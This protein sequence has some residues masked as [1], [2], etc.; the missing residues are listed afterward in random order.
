LAGSGS[1]GVSRI[2]EAVAAN[3]EMDTMCFSFLGTDCG[4]NATVGNFAVA[5][6]CVFSLDRFAACFHAVAN[7]LSKAAEFLGKAMCPDVFLDALY[8]VSVFLDL[9]GDG[10]GD[11]VGKMDGLKMVGFG[12][13]DVVGGTTW[14]ALGTQGVAVASMICSVR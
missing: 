8:E 3:C 12:A 13:G 14:V 10:I 9:A 5:W 7:T 6:D 4:N 2:I 1:A 11:G